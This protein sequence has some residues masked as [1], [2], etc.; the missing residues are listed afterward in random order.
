MKQVVFEAA[1]RLRKH[2]E[3][4]GLIGHLVTARMTADARIDNRQRSDPFRS[5]L[6]ARNMPIRLRG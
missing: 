5:Q 4:R 3:D 2:P 6:C 1:K